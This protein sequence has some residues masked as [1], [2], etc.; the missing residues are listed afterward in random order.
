MVCQLIK[1]GYQEDVQRALTTQKES[2][3][4]QTEVSAKP[5]PAKLDQV[6]NHPEYFDLRGNIVPDMFAPQQI[7]TK[8]KMKEII[9]ALIEQ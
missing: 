6:V 3:S 9:K 4:A 5:I 1:N 2:N 8:D 7:I